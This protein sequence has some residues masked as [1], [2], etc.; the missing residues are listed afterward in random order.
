MGNCPSVSVATCCPN[1]SWANQL[2]GRNDP[3]GLPAQLT[4]DYDEIDDLEFENLLNDPAYGRGGARAR[5]RGHG[6][7]GGVWDRMA[8]LFRGGARGATSPVAV[9]ARTPGGHERGPSGAS[10]AG[11]ALWGSW[12]G[13]GAGLLGGGNNPRMGGYQA[14]STGRHGPSGS[15]SHYSGDEEGIDGEPE[16]YHDDIPHESLSRT[17][18]PTT[19]A[20]DDDAFLRHEE[21]AQLMSNEQI[22]RLT[23]Q[24]TIQ[25][26]VTLDG[27]NDPLSESHS[28]VR[29]KPS[30][31]PF[32]APPPKQPL[33]SYAATSQ[34]SPVSSSPASR[35]FNSLGSAASLSSPLSENPLEGNCHSTPNASQTNVESAHTGSSDRDPLPA[36]RPLNTFTTF[37]PKKPRSAST[38]A[39]SNAASLFASALSGNSVSESETTAPADA[40]N[41]GFGPFKTAQSLVRKSS[42][43]HEQPEGSGT[44]GRSSTSSAQSSLRSAPLPASASPVPSQT[45]QTVSTPPPI[46]QAPSPDT[47]PV[48]TGDVARNQATLQNDAV[49]DSKTS[50]EPTTKSA[51]KKRK[52]KKKQQGQDQEPE[53][54]QDETND[55]QTSDVKNLKAGNGPSDPL[56][57]AM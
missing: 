29:E 6:A 54:A 30:Q 53:P 50:L 12:G 40:P 43:R 4:F 44:E 33:T 35:Q 18:F 14:V 8:G 34:P 49:V 55:G 52:Q 19:V 41:D 42:L 16:L 2:V 3:R 46:V 37:R 20:D 38:A 7:Q 28:H 5:G 45:P 9:H 27:A 17:H 32:A 48:A 25:T 31:P 51:K 10:G 22:R 13:W 26:L 24:V 21:D 56:Q 23:S 15:A 1:W 11:G 39:A 36:V 47:L 57:A